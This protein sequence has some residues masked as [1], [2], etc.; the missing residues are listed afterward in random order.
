MD[1]ESVLGRTHQDP[2]PAG[3]IPH[4]Y[5]YYNNIVLLDSGR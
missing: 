4:Y 5:N 3:N 1:I 2:K